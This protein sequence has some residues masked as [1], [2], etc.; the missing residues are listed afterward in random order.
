[1]KPLSREAQKVVV[2]Q[3]KRAAPALQAARD[4]ELRGLQHNPARVDAL[5]DMGSKMPRQETWAA[6]LVEM[7]RLFMKWSARKG[8]D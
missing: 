5:L 4:Q 7:Q 6:G 2:E 3:W 1:M 8:P